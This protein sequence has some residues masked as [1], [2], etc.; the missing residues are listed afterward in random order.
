[1]ADLDTPGMKEVTDAA[2][3]SVGF[4]IQISPVIKD[5]ADKSSRVAGLFAEFLGSNIGSALEPIKSVPE[6]TPIKMESISSTKERAF[7]IAKLAVIIPLLLN[8]ESRKYL[9]SFAQGLLGTETLEG[10]TTAL[11]AIGIV[12]AGVFAVKV[13][14]QVSDTINTL[15]RLSEV[16]G[17]LF[18][19]T[20]ESNEAEV[21][22]ARKKERE[23]WEKRKEK[24]EQNKS[25]KRAERLERLEKLKK[26]K[27]VIKGLSFLM[28]GTLVAAAAGIAM[29]AAASTIIDYA[30][31]EEPAPARFPESED[32][33][34]QEEKGAVLEEPESL[35]DILVRNIFDAIPGGSLLYSLF[36]GKK[37]DKKKADA[38]P[39]AKEPV[40][41]APAPAPASAPAAKA[42]TRAAPISGVSTEQA[43]QA[44]TSF[45]QTDPRIVRP[46]EPVSPIV[47][48]GEDL[49]T[50]SEAVNGEKKGLMQNNIV[51]N[52]IDNRT[53]VA[54]SQPSMVE[55]GPMQHSLSVGR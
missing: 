36:K 41:N 47:S 52:V 49:A 21:D 8:E 6:A 12:L 46:S 18:N 44:R 9:A 5:A 34:V 17:V 27:K 26:L 37:D 31:R 55:Q 25:K 40:T 16:I 1:M 30:T 45:G 20:Q 11:K 13:F 10:I 32:E 43:Q 22:E 42:E 33:P 50:T 15:I 38:T 28:K 54:T 19:L 23:S 39:A 53:L 29:D 24:Y 7:D 2:V 48:K 3:N 14:Q 51:N 35:G 4:F